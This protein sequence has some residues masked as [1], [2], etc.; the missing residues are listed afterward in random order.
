LYLKW[1]KGDVGRELLWVE[2]ERDGE[3]LVRLGGIR[4]RLL[5]PLKIN[6]NGEAAKE[7]VRHH[8]SSV[9][10]L[11]LTKKVVEHSQKDQ[12]Q[13][14]GIECELIAHA[15]SDAGDYI[16][17]IT[18]YDNP[19]IGGEYRKTLHW[20]DRQTLLPVRILTYGWP[21]NGQEIVQDQLDEETLLEDYEYSD[22]KFDHPFTDLDFSEENPD[23]SFRKGRK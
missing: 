22:L 5:P 21:E 4:G 10:L 7:K 23:Y 15:S 8:I 13:S 9:S 2:G 20:I 14:Q 6:P 3:M 1:L 11:T 16:Q 19:E 17:V 18:R 12:K